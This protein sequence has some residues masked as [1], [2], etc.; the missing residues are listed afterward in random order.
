M[1]QE[2]KTF[3]FIIN[4]KSGTKL[5]NGV[6][7]LI[8]KI[9]N[10]ANRIQNIKVEIKITTHSNHATELAR[11]AVNQKIDVVVAV[12]GDG[13]VNEVGKGL[14]NS[15]T[16]MAIIPLGSGNG[17]AR[18]LGVPMNISEAIKRVFVCKKQRIDGG[19]ISQ[20]P[21]FCTAGLGFDA[22]V[23]GQFAKQ[24]SRG[25]VTYIWLSIL[26]FF[27][28]KNQTYEI[29]NLH[30]TLFTLTFANA[31][32]YGNN[33]YIAPNAIINDGLLEVCQCKPYPAWR[34]LEMVYRLFAG[35]IDKSKYLSIFQTESVQIKTSAPPYIHY[36]GETI[37]LDTRDFVVE[38]MPK[39]LWVIC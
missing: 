1:K 19:K 15:E 10:E 35:S 33:A 7:F 4:P 30:K 34:S 16:I 29:N 32:Q 20:I 13:T 18:Y 12:G 6:E 21:F 36:D 11:E 3:W 9:L 37:Q 23:A 17:L 8:I 14:L 22:E 26:A 39:C 38:I 25:L 28:F 24:N 2:I 31:S 5:K 27:R